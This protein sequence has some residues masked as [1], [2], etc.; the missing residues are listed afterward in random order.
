MLIS[1]SVHK[2]CVLRSY[3]CPFDHGVRHVSASTMG[4]LM[5]FSKFILCCILGC[6]VSPCKNCWGGSRIVL[7][8]LLQR[9]QDLWDLRFSEWCCWRYQIWIAAVPSKWSRLQKAFSSYTPL[10]RLYDTES[11]LLL[12]FRLLHTWKCCP[13]TL[14]YKVQCSWLE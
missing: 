1:M 4:L 12:I 9:C 2:K 11:F 13:H 8:H 6:F 3:I 14:R 10:L 7:L 5:T